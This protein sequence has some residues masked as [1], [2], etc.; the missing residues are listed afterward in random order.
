MKEEISTQ[1]K[2]VFLKWLTKNHTFP[3]RE[4]L[5]IL[6]YLYNHENMLEKSHFVEKVEQTPRGIYLSADEIDHE[7]FI[8][9]KNGQSYEDPVQAFH[10]VRLNWSSHL[11]LEIGFKNAWQSKEYLAVLEDNPYASWNQEVSDDQIVKMA[12]AL[13]YESLSKAKENLL[14]QI[15]ESL[16]TKDKKQFN[17]LSAEFDKVNQSLQELISDI[18]KK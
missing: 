10:E 8:F 13:N 3:V 14:N 2:K 15:N 9:Y 6:D 17:Q 16:V 12:Q 18:K 1:E 7:D 5:W 4:S 11:Y